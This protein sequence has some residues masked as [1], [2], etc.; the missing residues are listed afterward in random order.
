MSRKPNHAGLYVVPPRPKRAPRKAK[1]APV[2]VAEPA[3]VSGTPVFGNADWIRQR[4][5]VKVPKLRIKPRRAK[6][7][8]SYV[9]IWQ[10]IEGEWKRLF[11]SDCGSVS[12]RVIEQRGVF[13]YLLCPVGHSQKCLA[14]YERERPD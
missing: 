10:R 13:V 2:A 12:F 7:W 3:A 14:G 6:V 9:P 8:I 11:C 4:G 5:S 1:L